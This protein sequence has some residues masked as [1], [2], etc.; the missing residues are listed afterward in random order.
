MTMPLEVT[1]ALLS[2]GSAA[3]VVVLEHLVVRLLNERRGERRALI[4]QRLEKVYVPLE[5]LAVLWLQASDD[6]VLAQVRADIDALLRQHSHLLT[7][8]SVSAFYTLLE[9]RNVGACL[10]QQS[11]ALESAALK[12]AYYRHWHSRR[13]IVA[14]TSRCNSPSDTIVEAS[15]V[16]AFTR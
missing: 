11:F 8:A 3:M 13:D 12:Q 2:M 1:V 15:S 6:E 16:L 10:L 5:H 7:E 14:D 9:D 4:G